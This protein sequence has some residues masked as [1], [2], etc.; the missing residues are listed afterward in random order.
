L[1]VWYE[2]EKRPLP[3]RE[4][5]SVYGTV[6]SELMAQQTRIATMLP[7]YE[8]WMRRFPDFGTLAEAGEDEV[9][10]HWEG[11]GYYRRARS[12]HQLA[13]LY[14][15]LPEK[16]VTAAE[17][18]LLPGIGPYTAAAVSSI[19]LGYPAAV[20]DGNVARI[21][22]R[23][24][25]DRHVF[26]SGGE[27]VKIFTSLADA[28]LDR[29]V[30]GRHNQAMMELGALVCTSA[31][32]LCE[33]CPVSAFCKAFAA[34]E[35]AS[36]PRIR[37][38]DTKSVVIDRVFCRTPDA[39]LL[40][41]IP[42][43]SKRLAGQYELPDVSLLGLNPAAPPLA[44]RQ[45]TITNHRITERI[46]AVAPETLASTVL[47]PD[48]SWVP[49]DRLETLVLSGPHRRWVRELLAGAES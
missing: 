49:L 20:V 45:R 44:V 28:L 35:A 26:A 38:K 9:L 31:K 41:R 40:H 14:I 37:P 29:S 3:W 15:T 7:Y 16:P 21:L 36:L 33:V 23:L 34:G 11:L 24:T 48:L 18:A 22:A 43:G 19:A 46:H 13:K 8:R 27:A 10:R 12:L 32:P 47:P 25:D 2:R 39:L 1:A 5:P 42:E 6:V 4:S 30:P 17:W